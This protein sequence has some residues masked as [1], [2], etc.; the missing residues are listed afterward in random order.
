MGNYRK[1]REF[2]VKIMYSPIYHRHLLS[3]TC[4][5]MIP[6]GA[7]VQ[8]DPIRAEIGHAGPARLQWLCDV[9][10]NLNQQQVRTL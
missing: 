2:A 4:W 5:R 10:L 9:A 6:R 1:D 7:G 8:R 3:M